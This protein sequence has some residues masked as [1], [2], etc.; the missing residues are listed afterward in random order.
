MEGVVGFLF[1]FDLLGVDSYA[2][3]L[4]VCNAERYIGF[5]PFA[6][7]LFGFFPCNMFFFNFVMFFCFLAFLFACW[8]LVRDKRVVFALVCLSPIVLFEFSK[9]ENELFAY[10]LIIF[11]FYFFSRKDYLYGF[12]ACVVAGGFWLVAFVGVAY[13]FPPLV[14]G[15]FLFP[16]SIFG[17]SAVE[18]WFGFGFYTLFGWL[19]VIPFIFRLDLKKVLGFLCFFVLFLFSVKFWVFLVPYILFGIKD[20]LELMEEIK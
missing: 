17:N 12:L 16:L 18:S 11:A 7:F 6:E 4:F 19:L 8:L 13:L 5:Q 15:L 14:F 9:F 10:P 2:S 3:K 20:L 1:R